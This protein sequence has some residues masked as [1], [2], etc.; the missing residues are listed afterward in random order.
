MLVQLDC[1][2]GRTGWETTT[3]TQSSPPRK[4]LPKE[5]VLNNAQW[6][7]KS[8]TILGWMLLSVQTSY[9]S[10]FYGYWCTW[11]NF[12][13]VPYATKS[14]YRLCATGLSITQKEVLQTQ[15]VC[16]VHGPEW[17][18]KLV[19]VHCDNEAVASVVNT[20][21]SKDRFI[22]H[23]L[24]CTIFI[25]A[26][27]ALDLRV[28]AQIPRCIMGQQMHYSGTISIPSLHRHI[29][30]IPNPPESQIPWCPYW[31]KFN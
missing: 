16:A 30:W 2:G 8:I 18:R 26:T 13:E 11:G 17:S 25:K 14:G 19:L 9:P 20:G 6:Q 28:A 27:F 5:N 7:Q 21:Y 12:F 23:L 29:K 22:I 3:C 15:Q 24:S 10:W 1:H 31:S 4:D